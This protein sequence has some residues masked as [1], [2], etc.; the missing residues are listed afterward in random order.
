MDPKSRKF[1]LLILG[2]T[3][4]TCSRILFLFFNDPEGPNLLVVTV[5][6]AIVYLLSLVAYFYT[7]PTITG[8]KRILLVIFVQILLVAGLYIV[9]N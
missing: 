6:A 9:L 3:A 7:P 5:L 8:L 1:A 2:L 4:I